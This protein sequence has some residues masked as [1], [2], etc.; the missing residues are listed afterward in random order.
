MAIVQSE[1]KSSKHADDG[2]HVCDFK[3]S[4]EIP[5]EKR[6]VYFEGKSKTFTEIRLYDKKKRIVSKTIIISKKQ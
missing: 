4:N 1:M 5:V 6:I 2:E 3:Y